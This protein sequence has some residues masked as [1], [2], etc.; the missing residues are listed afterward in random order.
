MSRLM[1]E[2]NKC[3]VAGEWGLKGCAVRIENYTL[4][5]FSR[6]KKEKCFLCGGYKFLIYANSV[7]EHEESRGDDQGVELKS[8]LLEVED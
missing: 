5:H 7:H 4:P 1:L 6:T 2:C 8:T 3:S